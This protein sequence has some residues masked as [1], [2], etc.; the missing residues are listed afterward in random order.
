MKYLKKFTLE[1]DGF[2]LIELIV[3]IAIIG[4]I[5]S[6]GI[7]KISFRDYKLEAYA[8]ELT[9][10]IR[11]TRYLKITKGKPHHI[12]LKT[13]RYFVYED[14]ELVKEVELADIALRHEFKDSISFSYKGSP[15][16]GGTIG[17]IDMKTKKKYTISIVPFTGRV[18]LQK[19]K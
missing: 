7:T 8:K 6:I 3:V 15:K 2:T 18:L 12:L 19:F 13:D 17:M 14:N 9:I 4:I 11:K 1:T 16:M 10:D 5:L